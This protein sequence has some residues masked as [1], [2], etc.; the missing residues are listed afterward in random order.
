MIYGFINTL[1]HGIMY[2]YYLISAYD[3]KIKWLY[4]CKKFITQVQL[5]SFCIDF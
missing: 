1:V 3:S 4:K 5:V 2:C